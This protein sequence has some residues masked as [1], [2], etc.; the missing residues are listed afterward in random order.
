MDH[1]SPSMLLGD[2][3]A[4]AKGMTEVRDQSG[5]LMGYIISPAMGKQIERERKA[6]YDSVAKLFTDEELEL[7]DAEGGEHT[8]EEVMRLL[9]K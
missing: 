6:F 7:A 2:A 3:L 4:N 5:N 8:I 1:L 9:E